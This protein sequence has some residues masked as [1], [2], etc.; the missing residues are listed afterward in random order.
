M[1]L[2]NKVALVTGGGRG[3][4]RAISLA[5]A[6]E[7]AKVCVNYFHSKDAAE[8]VV[9]RIK[10]NGGEAISHKA[11]VSKLEA[12]NRMVEEINKQ[13][14]RIDILVNNAGLNIDK[15][16]M[17]MNE[18][19]WDKVIDVNLK[20]TFNC[21]KA[22]SRVMI[23]Q[24]SGNIINIS[25]VSAISGTAGQTNYSAAKGGMISFTKSL[26]RELAPFDIRVNA[27]APGLIETEMVK[28]MP[29]EML[30]RIL[31][32]TPLKRVGKP[33]EVAKAVIFL[34]S[35][36]AGYITGQVIRVDGGLAM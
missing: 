11:D 31:E 23:G 36:E 2:K 34:V 4:G 20:G 14:G 19:E 27:L 8:E 7:G 22:V 3:I 30:D 18:E 5:L 28:K 24:R 1:R 33:E 6:K 9:K 13:F 21:S 17:I 10:E 35:E 29:K 16:L 12:V 26:A 32:I 15:Y 25:S